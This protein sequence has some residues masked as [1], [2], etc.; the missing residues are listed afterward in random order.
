MTCYGVKLAASYMTVPSKDAGK[1]KPDGKTIVTASS[2][3]LFPTRDSPQY[4]AGRHS[5]FS[6]VR[7]LRRR[8]AAPEANVQ[9][10][11]WHFLHCL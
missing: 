2:T 1:P 3:W 10:L 11:T 9:D 4:T 5:L 8:K 7:A 6:L